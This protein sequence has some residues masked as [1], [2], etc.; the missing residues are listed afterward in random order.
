MGREGFPLTGEEVAYTTIGDITLAHTRLEQST[1]EQ[2][3]LTIFTRIFL[4]KLFGF[5][6]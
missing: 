3:P 1:Y 5:D 4:A 6:P 2:T